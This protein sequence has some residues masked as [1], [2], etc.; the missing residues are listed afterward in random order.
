MAA[1]LQI[2]F[3]IA[4]ATPRRYLSQRVAE[5]A[6]KASAAFWFVV[7]IAGQLL[8]AFTVASFYGA[9]AARGDFWAWN[10]HMMHGYA[11]GDTM[12]NVAVAIHLFSAVVIILAGAAQFV[13]QL[14][15]RFPVF[16]RWAGRM[17]ILTAFTL[18]TAG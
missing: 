12:G 13:P 4:Y 2:T 7:T 16:H 15:N 1:E 17:Y 5:K 11:A 10:R 18:T 3:P 9:T 6:L 14:R 8:F